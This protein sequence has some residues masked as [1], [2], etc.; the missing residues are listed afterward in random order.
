MLNILKVFKQIKE[1]KN[2]KRFTIISVIIA[3]IIGSLVSVAM[4][5]HH[6]NVVMIDYIIA[7]DYSYVVYT[8]DEEKTFSPI[9][10]LPNSIDE[11]FGGLLQN[12]RL[13]SDKSKQATCYEYEYNGLIY[14]KVVVFNNK[15]I[16]T[17]DDQ[18]EDV[19]YYVESTQ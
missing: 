4:T 11:E 7:D 14:L 18:K 19:F 16:L 13:E 5:I 6:Y 3:L 12:V 1:L 10:K 9:E 8:Y 17:G 2:L 15:F